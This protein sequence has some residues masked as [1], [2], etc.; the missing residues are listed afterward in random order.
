MMGISFILQ[1]HKKNQLKIFQISNA[2]FDRIE[3]V[4]TG[5]MSKSHI[6]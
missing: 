3:G 6:Y 1:C 5:F 2:I 4:L